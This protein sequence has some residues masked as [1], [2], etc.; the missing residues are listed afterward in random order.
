MASGGMSRLIPNTNNREDGDGS[1]EEGLICIDWTTLLSFHKVIQPTI[2]EQNNKKPWI[3]C[4]GQKQP[5]SG[6]IDANLCTGSRGGTRPHGRQLAETKAHT[7]SLF[8][9][10]LSA[11]KKLIETIQANRPLQ[12]NLTSPGECW[13]A[14]WRTERERESCWGSLSVVAFVLWFSKSST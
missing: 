13:N 11:T 5:A 10:S 8:K 1:Q 12:E 4:E 3:C 14:P 9:C 7:V 2:T 6:P